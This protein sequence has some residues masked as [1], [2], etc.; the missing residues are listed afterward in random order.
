MAIFSRLELGSEDRSTVA[1]IDERINETSD[2][3]IAVRQR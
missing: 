2:L 3:R 1:A